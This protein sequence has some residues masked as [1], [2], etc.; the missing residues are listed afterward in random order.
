WRVLAARDFLSHAKPSAL[1]R[2]G[3]TGRQCAGRELYRSAKAHGIHIGHSW[4]TRPQAV[5]ICLAQRRPL[6]DMA[7]CIGALVAILGSVRRAANANAIEQAN[8]YAGHEQSL[9]LLSS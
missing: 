2:I 3:K 9:F 6:G 8:D 7:K 4:R 5:T 1:G